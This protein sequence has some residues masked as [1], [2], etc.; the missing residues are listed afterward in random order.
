MS[1]EMPTVA[2]LREYLDGYCITE[3]KISDKTV[4]RIRDR[5]TSWVESVTR[6]SITAEKQYTEYISGNGDSIIILKRKPIVSVDEIT[7]VDAPT[8]YSPDVSSLEVDTETAIIKAKDNFYEHRYGTFPKGEKNIKITYT[9]GFSEMPCNIR[10]AI[11]ALTAEKI[12]SHL[13]GKSGGGSSIS[14]NGYSR[15]YGERGKYTQVRI[16]LYRW[17]L[18]NLRDYMTGV[19]Q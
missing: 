8:V 4:E 9:A 11:C 16:D 7:Y 18:S 13:A 6:L 12:L 1:C 19:V 15:N 5:I 17:G 3:N 10:E 14:M 2:E